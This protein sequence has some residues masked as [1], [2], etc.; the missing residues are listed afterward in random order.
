[1]I[2][3]DELRDIMSEWEPSPKG[4]R[5]N[6]DTE[7][8][9]NGD[10]YVSGK[11]LCM[12]ED[13]KERLNDLHSLVLTSGITGEKEQRTGAID[14]LFVIEILNKIQQE[15]VSDALYEYLGYVK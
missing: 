3:D 13:A 9:V 2:E 12:V 5:I 1:M 8:V 10:L 4:C 7:K 14:I 11:I 15:Y 6:N